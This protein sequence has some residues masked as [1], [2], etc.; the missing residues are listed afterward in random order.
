MTLRGGLAGRP[1][2][3]SSLRGA[4]VSLRGAG[5]SGVVSVKES[6]PGAELAAPSAASAGS[7][8]RAPD[9]ARP[10][11]RLPLGPPS[12][13]Q[14]PLP[15]LRL[16]Q[17]PRPRR[18]LPARDRA[19]GARQ[20]GKPGTP[21]A[22]SRDPPP[23]APS[24]GRDA[25][26]RRTRRGLGGRDGGSA[27]GRAFRSLG[28]PAPAAS[29]GAGCGPRSAPTRAG[30][31]DRTR[32]SPSFLSQAGAS[33]RA[34]GREEV[35][36]PAHICAPRASVWPPRSDVDPPAPDLNRPRSLAGPPRRERPLPLAG[37]SETHGHP[38]PSSVARSRGAARLSRDQPALDSVLAPSGSGMRCPRSRRDGRRGDADRCRATGPR[39][40]EVRACGPESAGGGLN[41]KEA[42]SET[43]RA[44]L[45]PSAR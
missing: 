6:S 37:R 16:L 1:A 41:P 25:G 5:R 18:R 42:V 33:E 44:F 13:P 19:T 28:R 27:P 23:R 30:G 11:Q 32:R 7:A 14:G 43:R 20:R 31:T 36:G 34:G 8:G 9:G 22:A 40:G 39:D 24:L 45:A 15:P 10:R 2:G 3:G 38:P 26:L 29:R 21:A 4:G 12:A 17:R 35:P